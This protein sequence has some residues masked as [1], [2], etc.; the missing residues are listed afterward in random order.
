MGLVVLIKGVNVGGHRT[1]RPTILARELKQ[2][3]AINVGAA[4]T[5]V[6]RGAVSRTRLRAAFRR[7]LPFDAE[8]MIC[9]GRD[10]LALA[11]ED[12]FAGQP[13]G[14]G[15][16]RFV[17]VLAKRRVLPSA[18]PFVLPATGRWVVKVLARHGRF[19]LG[20]HRREMRAISHLGQLERA[21]GGPMTTRNW[22][23]MLTL[24]RLLE[25]AKP[26]DRRLSR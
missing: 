24:A 10:I 3:G 7:H 15:I 16:I 18:A 23:T 12:P 20:V 2:Y 5:F 1:F 9:D 13:S 19:V 25:A 14:S 11:A 22:N 17:S 8:I 26:R 6:I 4:G 21:L